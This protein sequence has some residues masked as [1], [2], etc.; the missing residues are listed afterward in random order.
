M[1]SGQEIQCLN[2]GTEIEER[3]DIPFLVFYNGKFDDRMNYENYEASGHY[4]SANCNY[5]DLQQKLKDALECNQ[6]NT[7]LQLKYQVKEGYQPLR[8]KDDQSLHFYIQLKAKDPDFTTYPMCVN[9]INNPTTTIDATFFGNDNSLITHRSAFQPIEYNAATTEDST[10][11]QHIIEA[12]S[13]NL[14][15]KVLTSWTMQNLWR[16]EMVE[17]PENNEKKGTEI[18]D[19]DELLITRSAS[20]GNRRSTN[21][22]R[23]RNNCAECAWFLCN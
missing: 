8:I 18:T 9:V 12:K 15:K 10:N 13:W 21:I 19:Y 6:E 20:S 22:Q 1:E 17:Q 3:K 5:E 2:K 11:Q 14:G 23:Q 7:V 16:E 4:I